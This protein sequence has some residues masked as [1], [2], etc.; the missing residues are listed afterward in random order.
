VAGVG[1]GAPDDQEGAARVVPEDGCNEVE[2]P[3][4]NEI[5]DRYEREC[6][7]EL[8]PRTQAD[9]RKH[10]RVLRASFGARLAAELKPKDFGPFVNKIGRGRVQ[11]VRQLATLSAA[12][13]KAVSAWYWI[14]R[15]VLR[16]VQ[17]PKFKARDRLIED[18]E[19][20]GCHAVAGRRVQLAMMLAL[21]TGQ[22][23]GDILKFRWADIKDMALHVYQSKT[24]KRVAIQVNADLEKVLDKCWQA[25]EGKSE[26][27]LC[28]RTLRPYT[29]YGFA[30]VW[31]R[32]MNRYVRRGGK[33]FT[34]HDI[35]ALA[36]TKCQ[37]P[38]IAMRLLGHT[39]MAVTMR[40]YRRG[41][42]KVDALKLVKDVA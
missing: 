24:G 40:V 17:R 9:Y 13:T 30:A 23:R 2:N 15:N 26:Y 33:R 28:T 38:E 27:V 3:T 31:Q 37:T 10:L 32:T 7:P 19:F 18:A 25:G 36:A 20:S 42:E 41:V 8:A 29:D 6:L 12:F 11:K 21:L 5:L 35:R 16:D 4:V 14:D 22:R 39:N 34:F 1:E